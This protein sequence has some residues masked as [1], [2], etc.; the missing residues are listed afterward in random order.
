MRTHRW[1][2]MGIGG[3]FLAVPLKAQEESPPGETIQ[4]AFEWAQERAQEGDFIPA[5]AGYEGALTRSFGKETLT[6]EEEFTVGVCHL[7]LAA[8]SFDQ[9]LQG[10]E[11]DP[12]KAQLAQA[13]RDLIWP[14]S[15]EKEG[16]SPEGKET[17]RPIGRVTFL[18]G[19]LL[20]KPRPPRPDPLQTVGQGQELELTDH[21]VPGKTTIVLFASDVAPCQ[22]WEAYLRQLAADRDDWVAVRV[23]ID[24]EG[25]TPPDFSSPLAQQYHIT[26]VP[27]LQIYGPD[28]A[29]QKEGP[30]AEE[31][32]LQWFRERA[33]KE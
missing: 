10:G 2:W 23:L 30:E 3:F 17:S 4:E 5:Q 18:P 31:Q 9:L 14:G 24:R 25:E 21:L 6:P 26:Q 32:L 15:T 16:T 13:W 33:R 8:L 1:W 29:L 28:K 27:Y 22:R 20:T 11:V 19:G 12:E 7:Y